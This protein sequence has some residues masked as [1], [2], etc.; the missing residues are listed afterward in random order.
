MTKIKYLC[1]QY[2]CKHRRSTYSQSFITTSS[3]SWFLATLD[4]K[5]S[6]K[7]NSYFVSDMCYVVWQPNVDL[8]NYLFHFSSF[9]IKNQSTKIIWGLLY[10][11]KN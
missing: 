9:L 6:E 11:L 1:V 4:N 5:D 10:R 7:K 2:R 8:V 3:T